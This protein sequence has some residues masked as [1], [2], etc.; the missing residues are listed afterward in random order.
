MLEY[1]EIVF[2]PAYDKRHEDPRKNYGIHGA[3]IQFA[4]GESGGQFVYFVMM[5][6]WML[7]H[8]RREM[9]VRLLARGM[10]QL[11][12]D[13]HYHPDTVRL[14]YHSPRPIY[15]GQEMQ[16]EECE[17]LDG[18]PCYCG[19]HYSSIEGYLKILVAGGLDALWEQMEAYYWEMFNDAEP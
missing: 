19:E 10:T 18:K 7:P 1:K 9:D 6:K 14:G 13:M 17:L 15:E 16:R 4:L 2:R 5:T 12:L 3:E 8:V 11:D